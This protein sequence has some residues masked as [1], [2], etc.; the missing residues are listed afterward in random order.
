[1]TVYTPFSVTRR[2]RYVFQFESSDLSLTARTGQVA[3]YTRNDTQSAGVID[4]NG[5]YGLVLP[6][7]S[8][9]IGVD[10]DFDANGVRESVALLMEAGTT[11]LVEQN[12]TIAT[13]PWTT[14]TGTTPTN[15]AATYSGLSYCLVT[16]ADTSE[17]HQALTLTGDGIKA[18]SFRMRSAGATGIGWV[19][20]IFD[21]TD[22][23]ARAAVQCT[24]AADMSVAFS[25]S[26]GTI[27]AAT[28]LADGD[29]EVMGVSASV[30]AA[31]THRTYANNTMGLSGTVSSFHI[32]GIQVENG[33]VPTSL[34]ITTSAT[35]TRAVDSLGF[36][37]LAL[38]QA[39]TWYTKFIERGTLLSGTSTGLLGI[40]ASTDAALFLLNN[41]GFYEVAHRRSAD[42]SS[43]LTVAPSYGQ[44]VELR[45]IVNADG[46]VQLGQSID[47]GTETLATAS[48]ANAF[49]AAW[50]DTTLTFADR[51]GAPG[52]AAFLA[53]RIGAGVQTMAQMRATA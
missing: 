29:Y 44:L 41:G 19:V 52:Y 35:G 33:A 46:S 22:G 6:N 48:A 5:R 28:R 17:T 4:S 40:G 12:C 24:F 9:F 11:N 15:A 21:V 20:P 16:N 26:T 45:A 25:A 53:V 38:P 10:T 13:S 23:V 47:G 36:P 32:T 49:A 3:T 43:T 39:S 18:W 31:H 14:G 51:G 42:V 34:I 37:L 50:H 8:R 1:M 30:T 27:L 2:S 7:Q